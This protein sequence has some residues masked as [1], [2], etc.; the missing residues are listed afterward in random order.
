MPRSSTRPL[1]PI[2]SR[3]ATREILCWS[4]RSSCD[5]SAGR[6]LEAARRARAPIRVV[7]SGPDRDALSEAFPEAEFLG[8]VDDEEL[9]RLYASA[10][11]VVIPSTEEFGIAAV[12]A[13][14]AG[15]PV[16]AAAA[17]RALETVLDGQTG[18]LANPG[19]V[20]SFARA[21]EQIEALDFDP[22]HAVSNAERFSVAAFQ[23]RLSGEVNR[24][25]ATTR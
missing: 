23:R 8:R 12:E 13:Q 15:R 4:F 11:A 21:I 6:S 7:G 5:T 24:A 17:G 16:I 2:A 14:A 10:R 18:I 22:A 20:E 25:A 19:D 3:Q 9:A 1:K